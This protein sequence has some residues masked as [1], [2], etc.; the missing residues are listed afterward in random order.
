MLVGRDLERLERWNGDEKRRMCFISRDSLGLSTVS[1][2]M[3]AGVSEPALFVAEGFSAGSSEA[4]REDRPCSEM[5]YITINTYT[6]T[7]LQLTAIEIL[8][9]PYSYIRERETKGGRIRASVPGMGPVKDCD[10]RNLEVWSRSHPIA[11]RKEIIR[12]IVWSFAKEI[13]IEVI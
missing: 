2:D 6:F 13:R 12:H 3:R 4:S 9:W 1:N 7:V 8:Y 10:S 11:T 5:A